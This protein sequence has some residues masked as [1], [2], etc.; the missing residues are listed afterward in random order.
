MKAVRVVGIDKKQLYIGGWLCQHSRGFQWPL[1]ELISQLP[2]E[3]ENSPNMTNREYVFI[4]TFIM[5]A[6]LREDILRETTGT[7]APQYIILLGYLHGMS[8]VKHLI[9][10]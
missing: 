6:I 5:T 1:V 10:C 8:L 9:L 2:I 7:M 4:K 3:L